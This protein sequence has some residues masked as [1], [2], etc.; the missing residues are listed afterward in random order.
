ME[1]DSP[2]WRDKNLLPGQCWVSTPSFSV[3]S[4]IIKIIFIG[5]SVILELQLSGINTEGTCQWR[6]STRAFKNVYITKEGPGK[7]NQ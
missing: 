6:Q 3:K 1:I 4:S 2:H 5:K 7:E